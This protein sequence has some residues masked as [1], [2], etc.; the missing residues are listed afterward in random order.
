MKISLYLIAHCCSELKK[1]K[2]PSGKKHL[3]N[4]PEQVQL[5]QRSWMTVWFFRRQR[6]STFS[7]STS[8][9]SGS[10]RTDCMWRQ[11]SASSKPPP[12][13][14][15]GSMWCMNS[16]EL[17]KGKAVMKWPT[18]ILLWAA[19]TVP[20]LH[21]FLPPNFIRDYNQVAVLLTK[22]TFTLQAFRCTPEAEV[23]FSQLKDLFSSVLII[24]H[25]NPG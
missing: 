24:A 18:V 15:C 20:W 16:P 3:K 7:M 1:L 14:S 19:A 2:K 9:S 21:K 22:L 25:P 4:D 6:R 10:S 8:S 11:R 23:A 17:A 13:P 12:S 5:E